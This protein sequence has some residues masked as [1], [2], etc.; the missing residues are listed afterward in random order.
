MGVPISVGVLIGVDVPI[1]VGVLIGRY[2]GWVSS[3][4]QRVGVL[5][6]RVMGVL[7]GVGVLT[8]G[9]RRFVSGLMVGRDVAHEGGGH[10]SD[11]P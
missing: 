7:V 5:Y 10:Y 9:G 2:G 3:S 1:S 6:Q 11:G 8:V 4:A